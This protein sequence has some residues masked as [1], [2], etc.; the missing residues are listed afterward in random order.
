[1]IIIYLQGGLGNQMFQYATAKILSKKANT[2]LLIDRDFFKLSKLNKG[3]TPRKFELSI[4]PNEYNFATEE[5]LLRFS[6]LSL[7]NRVR[8]KLNMNYHKIYKEKKMTYDNNLYNL[9]AP[10]YLKGY[11]Q[12]YKYFIENENYVYELFSFCNINLENYEQDILTLI[13][14]SESVAIHLRRG[15]YVYDTT[16]NE[17]HGVCSND[18]YYTAIES[19]SNLFPNLTFFI[20]SDDIEWAKSNF[21]GNNY[22]YVEGAL[23]RPSSIDLYLMSCCK[24]NI[25][26]NSSFSWWAAWLNKNPNKYIICPSKWYAIEDKNCETIDL[27]PLTW[28]RI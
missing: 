27:I 24:H 22:I 19:I 28:K 21:K 20:F 9:N 3:F 14:N 4:F 17:I 6:P 23:G 10:I 12:S 26:A 13:L 1:M 25:I 8:K 16:I 5:E 2:Q 7:K 18:Y 15:D 11:F